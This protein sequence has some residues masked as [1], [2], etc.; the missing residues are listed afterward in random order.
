L[1]IGT[2]EKAGYTAA[3]PE[4]DQPA[5]VDSECGLRT[6]LPVSAQLAWPVILV[7]MQ[8]CVVKALVL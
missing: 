3:L 2:V 6:R 1:L 7:A 5:E 8:C 4:P